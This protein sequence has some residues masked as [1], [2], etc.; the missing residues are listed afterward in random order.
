VDGEV[1]DFSVGCH[2]ERHAIAWLEPVADDVAL[3]GKIR[4]TADGDRHE[5]AVCVWGLEHGDAITV[6]IG[7]DLVADP[8]A[9]A[10]GEACFERAFENLANLAGRAVYVRLG[11][12]L[13]LAG[14]IPAL[15]A[16]KPPPREDGGEEGG[17]ESPEEPNGEGEP[18]EGHDEEPAGEE[19]NGE[20][21]SDGSSEEGD[22]GS[23]ENKD[24]EGGVEGEP[25]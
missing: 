5:L 19:P 22:A 6:W 1:T 9:N 2:E 12:E 11:D 14:E 24:I 13:V 17:K 23:D 8:V 16:E 25:R 18:K 15:P 3:E 20:G 4:L 21:E 7:D 10:E